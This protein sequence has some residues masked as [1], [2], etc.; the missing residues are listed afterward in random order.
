M[1]LYNCMLPR[2]GSKIEN[3]NLPCLFLTMLV[4]FYNFPCGV[5]IVSIIDVSLSLCGIPRIFCQVLTIHHVPN[6]SLYSFFFS[7]IAVGKPCFSIIPARITPWLIGYNK[8]IFWGTI[9]KNDQLQKFH[10]NP[11]KGRGAWCWWLWPSQQR[12]GW[13]WSSTEL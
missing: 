3:E 11:P 1:F 13:V 7:R 12:W 9:H 6:C 8:T 2:K 4:I 5:M 10:S